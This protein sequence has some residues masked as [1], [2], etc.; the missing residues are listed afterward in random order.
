MAVSILKNRGHTYADPGRAINYGTSASVTPS[1]DGWLV[2]IG[3]VQETQ[4]IQPIIRLIQNG[5]RISE[6]IGL[7]TNATS[8]TT[9]APVKAGLTYTVELFRCTLTNVTLY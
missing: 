6:G 1:R 4:T 8:L 5:K 2:A 3:T 7:T 9:A